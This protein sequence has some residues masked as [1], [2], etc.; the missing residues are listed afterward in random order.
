MELRS[1]REHPFDLL[2]E[3]ERRSKA[4]VAGVTGDDANVEEWIGI[5]FRLGGESFIVIR[6][7]VREVL[8]VPSFI[9][10]VPGARSWVQGLAN[11]RGHLLSLVDLKGFFGAGINDGKRSARVLV[12]NSA[13]SQ[14]GLIVDEVLGFRRFLDQ[15]HTSNVPQTNIR[16][17][18]FLDGSF[19]R[20]EEVWPVF[21]LARLLQSEEFHQAADD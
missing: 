6:D 8:M 11:V 15:E 4:A 10:R 7:M 9:T 3:L 13:E 5:G 20:G 16:C 2:R 17:E 21:N 1:L 14:V 12:A 18:R 19:E